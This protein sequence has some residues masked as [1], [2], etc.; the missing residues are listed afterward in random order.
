[1]TFAALSVAA[2]LA[3]APAAAHADQYVVDHCATPDGTPAPAFPGFTGATAVDCGVAGGAL[4][5]QIPTAKIGVGQS[6]SIAVAVPAD[7]PNI[8]IERVLTEWETP[9]SDSPYVFMPMYNGFGQEVFN[10]QP[11]LRTQVDRAMPAGNRSLAWNVYCG[12][13]A[14]CSFASEYVMTIYRTRLYLNESV[15]PTLTVTGGTLTGAGAKGA[16]QSV[17]LD[18]A[19]A[20]SGV[21]S[22]EVAL[23]STVVGSAKLACQFKDWSA[24]PR[25]ATSKV[26]QVDTTKVPDGSHELL[27]TV[28][29]AANNARTTSLG[30]VTIA[31]GAGP[32]AANGGSASRLAK[33]TA[34]FATTRK[35]SLQLRYGSQ[36]TIRGAVVTEGGQAIAG[37]TV[38]VLQRPRR[39]GA[40]AVQV[41][42]VTTQADGTFSY[43]LAPGP[44]RTLTFAYSAFAN[45]PKPAATSSL[46][47]RVPAVMSARIRPRALRAGGRITLTGR[48]SLL[49]REGVEV[50]IQ[51]RNG[52]RWQTIATVKTARGGTFRWRY[53]FSRAGAGRTFAFRVRSDSPIYPFAPGTSK[54]MLVRVR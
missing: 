35:R 41:A 37:A 54:A 52:R 12:G 24:C 51:A 5:L 23:G 21:S 43:K 30:T 47:T 28:R 13:S 39:A 34:G 42:T 8:Q 17:V 1:M 36:P 29:D 50:K 22:A 10:A 2:G 32:G 33:I 49:G 27:V 38:A 6:A 14:V 48:L 20:D 16:Q 3:L 40:V 9:G 25:D 15:A 45:D 26:V 46:T 7:R 53:R 44:S 11:P 18:A 4:R 19:D 31:N